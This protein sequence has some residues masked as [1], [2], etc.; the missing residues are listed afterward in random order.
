MIVAYT[1]GLIERRHELIDV[2][3]ARLA[4]ALRDCASSD[5]EVIADALVDE[6]L[7]GRDTEDDAA[8]LVIRVEL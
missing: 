4:H 3:L 5:V 1:D 7:G 8:L 2:G 6:C